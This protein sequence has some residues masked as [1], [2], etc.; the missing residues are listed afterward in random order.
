VQPFSDPV[1]GNLYIYALGIQAF[2]LLYGLYLITEQLEE[3]TG[4]RNNGWV[5]FVNVE[6]LVLAFN[7]SIFMLPI[8]KALAAS[9]HVS[10]YIIHIFVILRKVL[11]C[12]S[13]KSIDS[14]SARRH[15]RMEKWKEAR[16]EPQHINFKRLW[17]ASTTSW[18]DVELP[19]AVADYEGFNRSQE[20]TSKELEAA[21]P[22]R[23]N[24]NPFEQG[25]TAAE[26][27]AELRMQQHL[28]LIENLVGDLLG[29]QARG[30]YSPTFQAE[31][32][33][34]EHLLEQAVFDAGILQEEMPNGEAQDSFVDIAFDTLR[35]VQ[36][37]LLQLKK[38]KANHQTVP[39]GSE[40]LADMSNPRTPDPETA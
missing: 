15:A 38:A 25:P 32:L 11:P 7:C 17:S 28:T 2:T 21:E 5:G 3:L 6:I 27:S 8:I 39:T 9:Q 4:Q 30:K 36:G 26:F 18:D 12:I 13:R 40:T 19:D 22:P 34:V 24:F 10:E 37:V 16:L 31:L 14:S 33:D 23:N 35:F 1:L 20:S 29:Q